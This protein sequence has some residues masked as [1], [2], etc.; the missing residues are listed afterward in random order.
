MTAEFQTVDDCVDWLAARPQF[1]DVLGPTNE[2]LSPEGDKLLRAA[3]R[4]YDAEEKALIKA[5]QIKPE[6]LVAQATAAVTEQMR[7]AQQAEQ[8]RLSKLGPDDPMVVR[9][10]KD[11]KIVNAE[12]LD[13]R[14][15]PACVVEAVTEWVA[16]RNSWVKERGQNVIAAQVTAWPGTI[17]RGE[18]RVQRGGQFELD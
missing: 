4:P 17:P 8:E 7:Q 11:G 3:L 12:P 18:A 5:A 1:V 15:V 14:P 13:K 9:W 10:E 16:E 2:D 6:D